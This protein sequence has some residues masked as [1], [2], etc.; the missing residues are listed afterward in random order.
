MQQMGMATTTVTNTGFLS[1]LYIPL[2]PLL[3]WAAWRQAPHW[4]TWVAAAG[5]VVGSWLL[6]GG[7]SLAAFRTGDWWIIGSS[8]PWAVHVM[9]VGRAANKLHG[10]MLVAC[11]QFIACSVLALALGLATEPLSAEGLEQALWP[12]AYAGVL[13]VG[14]GFTLQ[15]VAQRYSRPADSAIVL[16]SETVFTAAFGAVFMG[17]RMGAPGLAG[18]ALILACVLMVQLQPVVWR[19]FADAR[20]K[21]A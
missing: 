11:G 12:I 1:A 7:G 6:T 2:V 10:A 5:C 18:C 13:S 9:L 16:S 4:T 15:V 20:A 21:S 8:L 19:W 14:L 17:D 3:A